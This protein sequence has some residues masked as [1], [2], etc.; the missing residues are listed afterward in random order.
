MAY[1]PENNPYIPGDPYSYDLKWIVAE[2]KKAVAL[3]TPLSEDFE[4]LKEYVNTYF[5]NLDIEAEV[6]ARIDAMAADGSLYAIIE[7]YFNEY[8]AQF[9]EAIDEMQDQIGSTTTEQNSRITVLEGRMDGFS[10]LAQGSTTGD[11]ELQDIR[12]GVDGTVWPTAG[13]AVRGQINDVDAVLNPIAGALDMEQFTN[14]FYGLTEATFN[15]TVSTA[16]LEQQTTTAGV[17][18]TAGHKYFYYAKFTLG[19][20][21]VIP[22]GSRVLPYL[23]NVSAYQ[24]IAMTSNIYIYRFTGGES[25]GAAIEVIGQYNA[26]A[27]I[28]QCAGRILIDSMGTSS[29]TVIMTPIVTALV[30]I[31]DLTSNDNLIAACKSYNTTPRIILYNPGVLSEMRTDIEGLT[32]AVPMPKTSLLV[33]FTQLANRRLNNVGWTEAANGFWT[34][35]VGIP[36]EEGKSYSFE[37]DGFPQM[38]YYVAFKSADDIN[39]YNQGT[40]LGREY[41]KC[42]AKA[43]AGAKYM[44]FTTTYNDWTR[45]KIY[46]GFSQFPAVSNN[47]WAHGKIMMTLGDSLTEFGVWQ[48]YV[49]GR[50]GLG[51]I[52]NLGVGGAKINVFADNVTAANIAD[53]D[54]VTVMGLFNSTN[55]QPGSVTDP[56]SNAEN[57]SVCAGYKYIVDKLLT[58]KPTLKIF[59]MTPHR[60]RPNDVSAKAEAVKNVAAYYGLPCID[61]YNEAGFNEYTYDQYLTDN[62][63]ASFG[64]EGGYAQEAKVIAGKM[65]DYLA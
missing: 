52:K 31:T 12:T 15:R 7:P 18:I 27:N 42:F 53:V 60:P 57:A 39:G 63:H 24:N 49:G 11:A 16:T 40:F 20:G 58:L 51:E 37:T 26:S 64:P 22:A 46:E 25:A 6:Q 19:A 65:L 36:V 2:V 59:L 56:A 1:S 21:S 62:V 33:N 61:L 32:E 5:A 4:E 44:F 54:I 34:N 9:D 50:L 41:N 47:I 17:P 13:D 8:K 29:K 28:A 45:L 10:Q 48:T 43:P 55:S 14:K 30:D 3:Y 38:V 35:S 23:R